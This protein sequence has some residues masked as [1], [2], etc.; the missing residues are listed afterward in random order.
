MYV[1]KNLYIYLVYLKHLEAGVDRR[2]PVGVA[3]GGGRGGHGVEEGVVGAALPAGA[4]LFL[5]ELFLKLIVSFSSV[6]K[7]QCGRT[8][9]RPPCEQARFL[10]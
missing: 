8:G 2:G 1:Y 6:K 9:T 7:D 5:K 4:F 10:E 3:A